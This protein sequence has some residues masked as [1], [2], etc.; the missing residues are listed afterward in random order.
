MPENDCQRLL[1]RIHD[2][3]LVEV[4]RQLIR[5]K[6]VNPPGNEREVSLYAARYLEVAGLEVELVEHTPERAS[7]L[8]RLTSSGE[9][10][11]LLFNAHPD[12]VPASEEGWTY[13]PFSGELSHGKVWGRGASDMKGGLAAILVAVKALAGSRTPLRGDLFVAITAGEEVDSLGAYALVGRPELKS[14]QAIMVAEPSSNE[15]YVAEKGLL[16]LEITTLGKSAHGS[17]PELGTN[18]VMRMVALLAELDR[19]DIPFTPHPLLGGFSR[20]IN[21]ISGGLSTNV[22]PDRCVATI[23]MRTVPGQEHPHILRQVEHRIE[24]LRQRIPGFQASV[25]VAVDNPPVTTD[26][27]DPVVQR[28]NQALA[29]VTG[30]P[31]IPSGVRYYTD[32]AVFVPAL[33]IPMLI[34]G[35]GDPALAHQTDEYVEVARL[36]EAA[37]I[38]ALAAVELLT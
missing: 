4:C 35:P 25:T 9:L 11:G 17:M 19:L 30:R 38:Y 20:S 14:L 15:I 16:W 28:F 13:P 23:D 24:S 2:S 34:C 3:E 1:T 18:A 22:V 37:R 5:F 31:S 10:P 6:S 26:P 36:V 7:L 29:Q 27:A 12:T 32:A 8:A 33:Q 21:T